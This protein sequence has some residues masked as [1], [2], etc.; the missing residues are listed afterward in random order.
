MNIQELIQ[1]V[2]SSVHCER[3]QNFRESLEKVRV[4]EQR[5][6]QLTETSQKK[7]KDVKEL[8]IT[9]IL[10]RV[11]YHESIQNIE[12]EIRNVKIEISRINLDTEEQRQTEMSGT[13]DGI[14]TPVLEANKALEKQTAQVCNLPFNMKCKSA[15][16]RHVEALLIAGKN[17]AKPALLAKYKINE[18][19]HLETLRDLERD[20]QALLKRKDGKIL[21]IERKYNATIRN[22]E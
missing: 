4:I 2:P 22:T 18:E 3:A 1:S 15:D 17:K 5:N 16:I 12:K 7:A 21:D 14:Q 13:S 11:N 9:E 6:I 20:S 19:T 8:E 10:N